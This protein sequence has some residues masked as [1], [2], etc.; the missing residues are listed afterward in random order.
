MVVPTYNNAANNR[1]INNM[2]SILMQEYSNF[3]IVFIDDAS[4]DSTSE[5]IAQLLQGQTKLDPSKY[6]LIKNS[7]QMHAMYNLRMAANSYC[8][9]QDI[10]IIV[11]GDD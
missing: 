4:E 11:D 8:E 10:F 3:H 5:D 2:N 6:L 9:P 1:H 7:K